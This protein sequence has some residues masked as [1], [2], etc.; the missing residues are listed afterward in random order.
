[1]DQRGQISAEYILIAAIVMLVVVVFGVVIADQSEMDAVASAVRTGAEN[2][3]TQLSI[4]DPTMQPVRVTS[5]NMTGTGNVNI[6]VNF[7]STVSSMEDSILSS[8]NRSL[9]ESGYT[10][11]YSGGTTLSFQTSRHNYTITLAA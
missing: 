5:V 4:L 1:M 3:T 6:I 9:T 11:S 8:I 10:T 7:S 2:G